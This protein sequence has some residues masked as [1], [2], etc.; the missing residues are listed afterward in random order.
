ML[1][2]LIKRLPAPM[3]DGFDVRRFAAVDQ[4][5]SVDTRMGRYLVVAEYAL[6]VDETA[7]ARTA[8]QDPVET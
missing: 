6:L 8:K 7:P 2:R 3:M 1:I 4:I 5:Y